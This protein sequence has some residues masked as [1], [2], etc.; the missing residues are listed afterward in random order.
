VASGSLAILVVDCVAVAEVKPVRAAAGGEL[1]YVDELEL[2][3]PPR[4]PRVYRASSYV[5]RDQGTMTRRS[6]RWL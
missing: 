6:E 1:V 5:Q 3:E 2:V 4:R